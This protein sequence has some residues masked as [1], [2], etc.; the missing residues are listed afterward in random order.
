MFNPFKAASNAASKAMG[1]HDFQSDKVQDYGTGQPVLSPFQRARQEWDDRIGAPVVRAKNW[2]LAFFASSATTLLLSGA[3]IYT[4]FFRPLELWAV[5]TNEH[6]VITGTVQRFAAQRYEPTRDQVAADLA[7]W[8][9]WVRTRPA[10]GVKLRADIEKSYSFMDDTAKRK[11]NEYNKRFDP[12]A[13]YNTPDK[14][15]KKTVTMTFP[16][17][18]PMEGNSYHATW[19]E[20]VWEYGQ[21][22]PPYTMT[23]TFT[24]TAK[25]Q[26]NEALINLNPAGTTIHDFDW[27]SDAA[28]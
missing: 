14:L 5:P 28:P 26:T 7:Q 25:G 4:V 10:D 12:F 17:V 15:A 23:A 20:T 22:R 24:A 21:P 9:E 2:R 27:R 6:G 16:K 1:G 19:T 11:L 13:A 8:I 3:L 18:L